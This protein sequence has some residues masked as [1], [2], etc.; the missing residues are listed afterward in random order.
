M[1]RLVVDLSSM[2]RWVGP[3]VGL[4][5]VQRRYAAAAASTAWDVTFTVF[6][7]VKRTLLRV[8]PEVAAEIIAGDITCDMTFSPDPARMKMRFYDHWP[9]WARRLLIA[10][11]RPRRLLISEIGGFRRKNPH[12]AILPLLEKIDDWLTKATERRLVTREDGSRVQVVPLRTVAGKKYEFVQGDH[13]LLMNNDWAHTDITAISPLSRAAGGKVVVLLND[14]IPIQFPAWYRPHDVAR[15]TEYVN[16]AIR[17]ADRF[18]LTSRRVSA[19]MADHAGKLGIPLPD[20]KLVPLGCD[21]VR[22]STAAGDLPEPL[23]AGRY[24]LFVSTIEP[25]KNHSMLMEVWRRLALDGTIARSGMKLLFVGRNGWLVDDIIAKLHGH[26][27]YGKSLIHL[28]NVDDRTLS[29]LYQDSAFC[30]YPSIYEGYGLPP[31]EGLAYGK[32]LI[33]STGGAIAEVV[34]SFGLCLDPFD[35]DGWEAAIRRWI[36]SPDARAAYEL[37]AAGFVTRT[38]ARAGRET[39]DAVLAPFADSADPKSGQSPPLSVSR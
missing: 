18:I 25:R 38:W 13:L 11:I 29:R 26:P 2:L 39:L 17:L 32:A 21:N 30:A 31:V 3:P 5:R 6:D 27:E 4:V 15:F 14:I 10:M 20:V 33:A 12:S 24:I 23:E 36:T 34:G 35:V 37:K 28:D 7:P 8:S 1:P 16:R 9:N 22:K 19:D